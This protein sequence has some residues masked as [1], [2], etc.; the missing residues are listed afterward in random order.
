MEK[1]KTIN[2]VNLITVENYAKE[3]KVSRQ[4]VYNW[5][6]EGKIKQVTFLGKS[7][8]DKSTKQ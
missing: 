7:F 1:Q 5:I 2:P 8:L 6:K 4:S 3:E